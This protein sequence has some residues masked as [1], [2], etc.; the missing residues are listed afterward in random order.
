LPLG[1]CGWL[2]AH[3]VS[4]H[5]NGLQGWRSAT[6]VKF[7]KALGVAP[8]YF[9]IEG[10]EIN[11]ARVARELDNLGLAPSKELAKAL[12][13]PAFLRFI[14][15]CAKAM[16]AHKKNLLRMEKALKKV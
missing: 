8:V 3:Q 15:K 10:E 1:R 7:A 6:L 2:D 9:M 16:R 13:D 14:E 12:R 4:R 5:E 11:H